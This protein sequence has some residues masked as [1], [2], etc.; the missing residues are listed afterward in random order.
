MV[1]WLFGPSDIISLELQI[2]G[3]PLWLRK[4]AFKLRFFFVCLDFSDTFFH[5][6]IEN[7]DSSPL[8]FTAFLALSFEVNI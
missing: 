5:F 4:T 1:K 6:D 8:S 2:F 3:K 7:D